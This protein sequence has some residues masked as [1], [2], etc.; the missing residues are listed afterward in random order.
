MYDVSVHIR[1][2]EVAAGVAVGQSFVVEAEQVQDGCLQIVKVNAV[3][4]GVVAVVVRATVGG[5]R[6]DSRT[7]LLYTSPSPRD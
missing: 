6:L 2:A 5:S 3:L 7:C 4:G 1:Q